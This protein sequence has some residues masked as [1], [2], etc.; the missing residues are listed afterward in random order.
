MHHLFTAETG[1]SYSRKLLTGDQYRQCL[2]REVQ[3]FKV[4]HFVSDPIFFSDHKFTTTTQHDFVPFLKHQVRFHF[5]YHIIDSY[6]FYKQTTALPF[7]IIFQLLYGLACPEP[8]ITD[9]ISAESDGTCCRHKTGLL[10]LIVGTHL[11][12]QL[13]TSLLYRRQ[14]AQQTG[15]HIA[16]QPGRTGR[17]EN[18][19]DGISY[20][21][22]INHG[23]FICRTQP[24]LVDRIFRYPQYCRDRLRTSQQSSRFSG[25][26]PHQLGKQKGNKQ[27][28]QTH[29]YGKKHLWKSLLFQSAEELR[30]DTIS[31]GKKEQKEK[32]GFNG[33]PDIDM[34][35]SD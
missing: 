27:R 35:L 30:T 19:T 2:C 34:Q 16:H 7:Q 26:I 1:Y 13:F 31:H 18:I 11:C 17:T 8:V 20:R 21:H 15:S 14:S 3:Q 4:V 22:H 33:C 5:I 28:E 24:A 10:A 25:I 6:A 9:L 29:Q 12:F 32:Y 23:C